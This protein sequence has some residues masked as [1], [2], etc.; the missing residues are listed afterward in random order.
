MFLVAFQHRLEQIGHLGI[1][2]RGRSLTQVASRDEPRNLGN[3]KREAIHAAV[4]HERV[5]MARTHG[6]VDAEIARQIDDGNHF[7]PE[8][9]HARDGLRHAREL[10]Q[11]LRIENAACLLDPKQ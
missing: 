6:R 3:E 10:R 7:S 4:Q 8:G 1:R 11:A 2:R 9:G 5:T